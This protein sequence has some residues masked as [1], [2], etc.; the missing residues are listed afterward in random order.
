MEINRLEDKKRLWLLL[1]P[2]KIASCST[3]PYRDYLMCPS[4]V[5][6]DDKENVCLEWVRYV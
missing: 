4:G 5:V 2:G 6:V 1:H 3:C